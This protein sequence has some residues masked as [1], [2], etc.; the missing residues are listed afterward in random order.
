MATRA[1]YAAWCAVSALLLLAGQHRAVYRALDALSVPQLGTSAV[2]G[3]ANLSWYELAYV[4]G[5]GAKSA[6]LFVVLPYLGIAVGLLAAG[7][8]LAGARWHR[9]AALLQ[10]AC[11]VGVGG[12][13]LAVLLWRAMRGFGD[14]WRLVNTVA[15]LGA[16]AAWIL[17]FW[18]AP[19]RPSGG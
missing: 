7:G 6:R 1:F 14:P 2:T 8:L 15:F 5:G 10:L 9:R 4:V 12:L 18:R 13:G 16:T 11:G 3:L 19:A 17:V